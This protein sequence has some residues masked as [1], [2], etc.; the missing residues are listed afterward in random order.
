[1]NKLVLQYASNGPN[2]PTNSARTSSCDSNGSQPHTHKYKTELCR[3]F[4]EKGNCPYGHKCRVA[5]GKE[6]LVVL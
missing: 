4:E 5:H 3:T 1:M 6:D 2:S